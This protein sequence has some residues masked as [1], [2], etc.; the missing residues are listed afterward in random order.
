MNDAAHLL[1]FWLNS[2]LNEG[3][4]AGISIW[5]AGITL[6]A[7]AWAH[8]HKWTEPR[9]A[10]VVHSL[11]MAF[12]FVWSRIVYWWAASK[13]APAG[14]IY[15]PLFMEWRWL[16]SLV[17]AA[18]VMYYSLNLFDSLNWI[19]NQRGAILVIASIALASIVTAL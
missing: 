6:A 1:P 13:F 19:R 14:E 5:L 2:Y 16:L 9:S 3:G 10:H 7:L 17:C 8:E 11:G 4:N 12:F 18:G 15:H